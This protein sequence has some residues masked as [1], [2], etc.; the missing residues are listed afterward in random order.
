MASYYFRNTGS[1]S[2]NTASNWSLTDGGGATGAV[3]LAT[4]DAFFSNNSG[5]CVVDAAA[6]VCLA[7]DFTKGTGFVGTFTMTN[8]LTTAGNITLNG[9]MTFAGTAVLTITGSV[10]ITSNG[11]TITSSVTLSGAAATYTLADDMRISGTTLTMSGAAAIYSGAF[12]IYF[13]GTSCSITGACTSANTKL[14]FTGNVTIPFFSQSCGL[15]EIRINTGNNI[16]TLSNQMNIGSSANTTTLTY[17]SGTTNFATTSFI[18]CNG[19][20]IFNTYPLKWS[21]V[22]F[23]N[24]DATVRTI[25]INSPLLAKGMKILG[26]G[27]ST[28]TTFAGSFGFE[29]DM[30]NIIHTTSARVVTLSAGVTY[31]V[32]NFFAVGSN[33]NSPSGVFTLNSSS[34]GIK[35]RLLIGKNCNTALQNIIITD[36]DNIGPNNVPIFQNPSITSSLTRSAGWF[37]VPNGQPYVRPTNIKSGLNNGIAQGLY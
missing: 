7:L 6:R 17:V 1:T 10:T 25:T 5:N 30:L 19:N 29:C 4:D 8:T 24:S 11:I 13:S 35:S 12:T 37:I 18:V 16:F 36:V 23:N 9:A 21:F 33:I 15:N 14:E 26:S 20:V 28:P 32:N 2:W 31:R 22:D 3:P 27:T 34:S